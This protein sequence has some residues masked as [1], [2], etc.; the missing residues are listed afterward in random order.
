MGVIN[1]QTVAFSYKKKIFRQVLLSIKNSVRWALA[2]D[3]VHVL[4]SG[5][6]GMLCQE[7][8]SRPPT[9]PDTWRAA[10]FPPSFQQK[11]WSR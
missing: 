11:K 10:P 5:A 3:H 4:C 7:C 1:E 2:E 6:T 9:A 8:R